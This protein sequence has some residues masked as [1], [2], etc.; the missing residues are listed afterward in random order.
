MAIATIA[1]T[2]RL[3]NCQIASKPDPLLASNSDPFGGRL[4]ALAVMDRSML[5]SSLRGRRRSIPAEASWWLDGLDF[6]EVEFADG[7]QGLGGGAFVQVGRQ[8]FQPGDALGLHCCQ[9]GDGITPALDAAAA[10]GWVSVARDGLVSGLGSSVASLAFGIGHRP[11]ADR[12][13]RHGPLRTV[14][15]RYAG[16][17]DLLSCGS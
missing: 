11:V 8:C 10:V 16:D 4:S 17:T 7:L 3:F 5:R 1:D 2:L 9:F 12:F 14:T 13:A 6:G 15:S